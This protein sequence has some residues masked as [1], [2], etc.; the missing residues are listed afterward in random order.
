MLMLNGLADRPESD[1]ARSRAIKAGLPAALL[2]ERLAEARQARLA[3]EARCVPGVGSAQAE[4]VWA[5]EPP[6]AGLRC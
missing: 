5:D 6:P 4:L 3:V 1:K 2:Q